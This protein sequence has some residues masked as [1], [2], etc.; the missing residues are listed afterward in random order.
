LQLLLRNLINTLWRELHLPLN[1]PRI[2]V[3]EER[4]GIAGKRTT[5]TLNNFLSPASV[6]DAC[7]ACHR[8]GHHHAEFFQKTAE[9][10]VAYQ[11][12][13]QSYGAMNID[14]GLSSRC[15]IVG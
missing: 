1:L 6:T 3:S 2:S 10:R 7:E 13:H 9:E 5:V 15:G 12:D 14:L 11:T 4:I 8:E